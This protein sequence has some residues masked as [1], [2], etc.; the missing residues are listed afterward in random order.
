MECHI[1]LR[2]VT[3]LLSDGKTPY[4]RRFGQPVKG[5]IIPFGSL[6]EYYLI[7]AKDQSRK[8]QFG[9]KLLGLFFGY[10]LYAESNLEGWR[11]GCRHWGVGN[12]GRIWNLL[13]KTR[14]KRGEFPS[15]LSP[16]QNGFFQS[17][18]DESNFL[19]EIKTW[20][21]PLRY[22]I[23]QFEKKVTLIFF[24][25]LKGLFRHFT[26]HFRMPVKQLMIFGLCQETTYTAFTLNQES[27]FICREKSH[28]LLHWNTLT[29]PEWL[30]RTWMLSRSAASMTIGI[31][32]GQEIC[33]ILGQVSLRKLYWKKNLQTDICGP[34]GD[35]RENSWHP[36]QIIYGQNSGTKWE[37]QA[38]GEVKVVTW[39][40]ST[41]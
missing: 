19:E 29:S 37:S 40:T 33:L 38:E 18:M 22:G 23:V 20:E 10:A 26:T 11:I 24:D 7:Y 25:N 27:N 12:D 8:H 2:N 41:R 35:W 31:S 36:G 14:C 5:P 1:Y 34:G 9:Q 21:H 13:E 30:I 6:V 39:K 15:P 4:E 16:P 3:D 17:Q 28:S 32:M